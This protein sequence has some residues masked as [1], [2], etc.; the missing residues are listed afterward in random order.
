M[1]FDAG[2]CVIW[3]FS[4]HCDVESCNDSHNIT[5]EM[6]QYLFKIKNYLKIPK[7][8]YLLAKVTWA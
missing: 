8:K 1:Q 3:T 5:S 7:I 4:F 6:L 2:Q